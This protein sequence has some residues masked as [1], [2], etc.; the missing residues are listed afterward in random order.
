MGTKELEYRIALSMTK[1]VTPQLVR[2]LY[3]CGID[4]EE[5]YSIGMSE[6]RLKLGSKTNIRFPDMDREEALFKA[7]E[8]VK[9][10][11][12]HGVKVYS[13]FDENYP[14]LL[15]EISDPPII[16]YQ[17]GDAD[18]DKEH[19]V[20]IVGTRKPSLY[21]ID[22]CKRLVS[23]LGAYFPDL[24]V[25]SGLA[26]GIDAM[27]HTEALDKN[28]VTIGVL[29]HGLDMIYPSSNRELARR[30]LKNGG[31]LLSQY[32]SK[33][34]PFAAR[35]LERNRIVAGISPLTIVVESPLKGGAMSTANFAFNYDREVMALPGRISDQLSEG[36]NH[37]IRKEKAHLLTSA[38]DIIEMMGWRP[39]GVRI[40]PKQ[41][42]LFPD[43]DGTAKE[44]CE[45]LKFRSEALTIDTIH[46]LTQIPMPELMSTLVELE[47]D[48]IIN[49]FP[50]NRFGIA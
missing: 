10:V 41:R 20:S 49:R 40:S 24:T 21:G 46:T 8:E 27:A 4:P 32:P 39:L 16:L 28:L 34:T 26:Y 38:A 15:R 43:L 5:F 33:S 22:F 14:L 48:G 31:A 29:A 50:G 23:D 47:F 9:F 18:L 13:L 42:N 30:I 12:R 7:R 6:L 2:C 3:E 25:V 19:F 17:L 35:F 1:N 11:E 37:L 44:I 45:L 36:T